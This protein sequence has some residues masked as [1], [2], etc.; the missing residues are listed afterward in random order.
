MHKSHRKPKAQADSSLPRRRGRP[1]KV[2]L[3]SE[4]EESLMKLS[5][6][7]TYGKV[8]RPVKGILY[9]PEGTGKTTLAAECPKPIIIDTEA[10]S[11]ELTCA[12]ITVGNGQQLDTAIQALITEQNDYQTIGIDSVDWAEKYLL[13]KICKA[14]KVSDITDFGHGHGY[15]LWRDAFD[16]FLLDLNGFIRLG[17]HVVLI[18]HAQVKTIQLPG[19]AEPFDRFEL[20]LDKRNSETATEWADFQ[21]FINFD[22]HVAKGKDG[23]ARAIGGTDRLIYPVHTASYDAKNRIGLTEPMKLEYA[24]I[25]P[26]FGDIIT[27]PDPTAQIVTAKESAQLL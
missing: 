8:N 11:H 26:F 4:V 25:A 6:L 9:G 13:E 12:R 2:A 18:G 7:T 10:G 3:I 21:I 22:I 5:D 17:K 1:P 14:K 24:S 15:T 23:K 19:I 20:K 27:T 16:K